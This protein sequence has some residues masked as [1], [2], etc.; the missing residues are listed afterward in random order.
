MWFGLLV[1]FLF[2]SLS[3]I[4][5]ILSD[6]Y[7][8]LSRFPPPLACVIFFFICSKL[9]SSLDGYMCTYAESFCCLPETITTLLIGD[10]AAKPLQS[11]QTLCNPIDSSPPGSPVPGILQARTLEWV[12]ISFSSAW[13]WKVKVKSE[14]E[15]APSC[16]TLSDPMDYS[17]PGSSIHGI[18]RQEDWS[19]VPLLSPVIW[20]YSNIK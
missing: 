8:F 17:P 3:L 10:A 1:H 14:S 9:C 19:G 18:S 20:L 6:L 15:V 4:C 2:C 11:C 12:A 7:N 5:T 13:K 16:P